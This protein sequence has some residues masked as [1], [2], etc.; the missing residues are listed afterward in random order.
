MPCWAPNPSEGVDYRVEGRQFVCPSQPTRSGSESSWTMREDR[1]LSM[2]RQKDKFGFIFL[3]Q[4]ELQG[5]VS[6]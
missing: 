1:S 3:F 4:A 2:C 5:K 6:V